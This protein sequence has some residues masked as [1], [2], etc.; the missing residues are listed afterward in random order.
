MLIVEPMEGVLV[1]AVL[2]RRPGDG[3]TRGQH[4]ESFSRSSTSH[5]LCP[6]LVGRG[7]RAIFL[8]SSRCQPRTTRPANTQGKPRA[9]NRLH[10]RRIR[11]PPHH[12][13]A[14]VPLLPPA[15]ITPV[16]PAACT[17]AVRL[18]QGYHLQRPFTLESVVYR[19]VAEKCHARHSVFGLRVQP[20]FGVQAGVCRAHPACLGPLCQWS[21]TVTWQVTWQVAWED[22]SARVSR[23][24]AVPRSHRDA[25]AHA[26]VCRV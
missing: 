19:F 17:A 8:V 22:P 21:G 16:P 12:R 26:A 1:L 2:C 4:H 7:S 9:H 14:H 13:R 11:R 6:R 23:L 10:R 15:E 24:P 3:P 20:H 18:R 25:P 5:R